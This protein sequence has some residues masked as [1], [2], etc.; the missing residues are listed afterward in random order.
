M[1]AH[2]SKTRLSSSLFG[3]PGNE[4]RAEVIWTMARPFTNMLAGKGLETNV[5]VRC[6]NWRTFP[7]LTPTN[8]L[9]GL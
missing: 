4:A 7:R 5:R 6:V 8:V 3:E 9:S 1:Q 2:T